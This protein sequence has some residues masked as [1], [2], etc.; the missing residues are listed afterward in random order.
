MGSSAS[1][2]ARKLSLS[3]KVTSNVSKAA[4][5]INP[6][7]LSSSQSLGRERDT[8]RQTETAQSAEDRARSALRGNVP[9]AS[10]T[11]NRGE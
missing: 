2:P 7:S 9:R 5:S 8:N 10:E 1:K 3:S 11:K 6:T 4:T